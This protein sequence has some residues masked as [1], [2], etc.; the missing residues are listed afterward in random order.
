MLTLNLNGIQAYVPQR[1]KFL[2]QN[3]CAILSGEGCANYCHPRFYARCFDLYE[4]SRQVFILSA[5][6]CLNN[7][8]I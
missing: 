6:R 7:D 5:C 3:L 2:S 1:L 8:W 4:V